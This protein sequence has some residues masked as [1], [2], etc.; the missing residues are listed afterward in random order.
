MKRFVITALAIAIGLAFAIA[1]FYANQADSPAPNA[2]TRT[3]Q[4]DRPDATDQPDPGP[5]TPSPADTDTPATPTNGT[6][7][8]DA[9]SPSD[10]DEPRDTPEPADA[11]QPTATT[12]NELERIP[13]LHVINE[14]APNARSTRPALGSDQGNTPFKLRAE[15]TWYG[16]AIYQI[17]LAD[18]DATV[19]DDSPYTVAEPFGD[20]SRDPRYTFAADDIVVNQTT[21]DLEDKRWRYERVDPP[22]NAPQGAQA[23]RYTLTLADENNS[24]VLRITRTYVIKPGS[25][26]IDLYQNLTNLTDAP[27]NVTYHQNIQGDLPQDRGAYLGDRRMY[28]TGYVNLNYGRK[29]ILG[30][31]NYIARSTL[32][33]GGELW[34]NPN[35]D[36]ANNK[37]EPV[38]LASTNRYFTIVTHP[39]LERPDIQTQ[40]LPLLT[41]QF[42]GQKVETQVLPTPGLSG[43]KSL[44][45]NVRTKPI[46]LA[47]GGSENVDVGIF[48]GPRRQEAFSQQPVAAL[49]LED[50][51]L[52]YE[53]GCTFCTFQWLA[54]FLLWF[55]KLIEGQ[56]LTL[57][58]IAIG[59]FDWGVAIIVLVAVVRLLLHPLTKK[60]QANMMKMS[61]QMQALQP[62]MEKLKKK[63]KDDQQ[64]LNQEMMKLY[65]EKGVNP[66]GFLGCAPMLLQMPIWIALYAMLYFAIELRHE[67]AFYGL[68]QHAGEMF[69][70]Y[71]PFLADLSR[72][73]NFIPLPGDGFTLPL[74]FIEP[75]FSA[76]N[77]LPLLMAVVFFLQ[78]KFTTPPA[79]SEQ[80]AQQQ[81]MMKFMVLLFPIFLYSAPSGLTLYILASTTAGVVDSYLVRKHVNEQEEAGTLFQTKQPKPGGLRDRMQKAME[82]KQREM[83]EKQQAGGGNNKGGGKAGGGS[84]G[85]PGTK[86]VKSKSRKR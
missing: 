16:G 45:F 11:D 23:G 80:A 27:L 49:Q 40:D 6:N 77:I 59:V 81:K 79:T 41:E 33:E 36:T 18:Y 1:V 4:Q 14:P 30:S 85:S 42:D 74:Y 17:T 57:G 56:V 60:G 2:T 54:E 26:D 76:I 73:D 68:F 43:E 10:P 46:R 67:P 51:L 21:I 37:L 63:Y 8:T 7:A 47:A 38:W 53:L 9:A 39:L 65:R 55:L 86:R 75:Q 22:D 61:K 72:A 58:G 66:A 44:L 48:A 70:V 25:Y 31:Q 28:F 15:M 12:P 5:S 62:E 78:Q 84:G 83:M 32:V 34:P 50:N 29:R 52:V 20:V 64:K 35:L 24:P 3:T 71:W 13:G 82:Q 19:R 69:G